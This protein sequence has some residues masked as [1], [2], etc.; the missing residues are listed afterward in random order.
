MSTRIAGWF[1]G[2][3][4]ALAAPARAGDSAVAAQASVRG[5]ALEDATLDDARAALGAAALRHNGGEGS[6]SA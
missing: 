2:L 5:L 6:A 4:V 3:A 1:I